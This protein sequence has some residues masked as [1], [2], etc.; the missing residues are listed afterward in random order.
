ME[1]GLATKTVVITGAASGIGRAAALVFAREGANLA[2][3]DIDADSLRETA[4]EAG[5]EVR[6]ATATSDLSTGAGVTDGLTEAL[7]PFGGRA[8]VL[9][10]N[11]GVALPRGLDALS[12][13]DW[14]ATLQLN[15]FSYVRAIRH[16]IPSMRAQGSGAIVNVASDLGYQPAPHTLD[17]SISKTA[18]L[19]L[20]KAL[21]RGEGPSVRVNA[22]A[23]GPVWTPL[24]TRA[25]GLA[26]ALGASG[27]SPREAVERAVAA[28]LPLARLATPL[29][30]AN[31][32]VFLASDLASYV[33]G[34][35]W[36]VDGGGVRSL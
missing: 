25:G 34:S 1:T 16:V 33:T 27:M 4:E 3:I 24:W 23:P 17:Y 32:I 28:Q 19:S 5:P 6:S 15:F 22:V 18:I 2:L 31:V 36:G 35:V 11:V 10:N 30:I 26:Q 7:A 20:T 13:A 29:E 8:D 14:D 12:D 21:A 9:V